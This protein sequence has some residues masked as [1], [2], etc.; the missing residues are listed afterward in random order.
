VNL[1]DLISQFRTE[2]D[3][4]TTPP[5]WSDDS[6]RRWLNE[7]QDQAAIRARLLYDT[8]TPA[9]CRIALLPDER[10]YRL[11]PAVFHVEQ[12]VLAVNNGP[13]LPE[14]I[15]PLEPDDDRN[16]AFL[17]RDAGRPFR[18]SVHGPAGEFRGSSLRIDRSIPA[19]TEA[20]LRLAV[21]R[22]PLFP[23]DGDDEPEIDRIHHD[24]LVYWALSRAYRVRDS[25]ANNEDRAAEA[26]GQFTRFFG[27][28]PSAQ[29]MRA[30]QRRKNRTVR[31]IR[32]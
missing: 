4:H 28:L 2:A 7:A 15:R 27:Q 10:S 32:C 13:D 14:T 31:P 12:A 23:M 9:C 22:T 5:L 17:P 25:E 29:V 26:E 3:D 16:M 1:L 20:E 19:S 18:F 8:T 21:F 6:V 30:H 11:H 24:K